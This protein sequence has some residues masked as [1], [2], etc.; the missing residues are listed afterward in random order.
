MFLILRKEKE[1]RKIAQDATALALITLG[2]TASQSDEQG[3]YAV[4]LEN[5]GYQVKALLLYSMQSHNEWKLSYSEYNLGKS[6]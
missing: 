1:V 2:A 4:A 6:I 5:Q 3:S